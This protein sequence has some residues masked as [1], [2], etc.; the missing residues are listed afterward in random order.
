MAN[1]LLSVYAVYVL[2]AAMLIVGMSV[3]AMILLLTHAVP[4]VV[5]LPEARI[6]LRRRPQVCAVCGLPG[7]TYRPTWRAQRAS[8]EAT[9]RRVA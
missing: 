3:G 9:A 1:L 6:V 2:T 7:C 8:G 4:D 5:E